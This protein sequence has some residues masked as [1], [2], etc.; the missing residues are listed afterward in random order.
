[1]LKDFTSDQKFYIYHHL[2]VLGL[3][4][5]LSQIGHRINR[6]EKAI[7]ELYFQLH[8]KQKSHQTAI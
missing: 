6:S 7:K 1:M 3:E 4:R 2:N 5:G 8:K